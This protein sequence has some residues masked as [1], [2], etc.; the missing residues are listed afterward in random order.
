ML[1]A[2][3]DVLI[4]AA[5]DVKDSIRAIVSHNQQDRFRMF[6][7]GKT[8]AG[9]SSLINTLLQRE[10]AK[11][12]KSLRA[13]TSEVKPH[14]YGVDLADCGIPPLEEFQDTINDVPITLWDSPGLKDPY[15]D[16]KETLKEIKAKCQGIDLFVYCAQITQRRVGQD[17]F[18]SIAELTNALGKDIWKSALIALTF[19]NKVE[20]ESEETLKNLV[21]EWKTVL[22]DAVERAGITKDDAASIPVVPVSYRN[23]PLPGVDDWYGEFWIECILRTVG[24]SKFIAL[25]QL[26]KDS[27]TDDER[28]H[29][30]LAK[31]VVERLKEIGDAIDTDIHRKLNVITPLQLVDII[32]SVLQSPP[33]A[34]NQ[35]PSSAATADNRQEQTLN[36]NSAVPTSSA[37]G[38][39]YILLCAAIVLAAVMVMKHKLKC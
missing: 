27:W 32:A 26:T 15:T 23:R 28:R 1:A 17:E 39:V 16:G 10:V 14:R 12:G 25:L 18:D 11:E 38:A 9:K 31:R 2:H 33:A 35:N 36:Q 19:A 4:M 13:Q 30:E 37:R 34:P 22:Q 24:F 29:A 20:C 21:L 3:G 6:V 8:G 5:N 7:F